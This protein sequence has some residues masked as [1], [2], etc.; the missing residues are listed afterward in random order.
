MQST[1]FYQQLDCEYFLSRSHYWGYGD[2]LPVVRQSPSSASHA[3]DQ[4]RFYARASLLA[5]GEAALMSI[6][7]LL[8]IFLPRNYDLNCAICD[9]APSALLSRTQPSIVVRGYAFGSQGAPLPLQPQSFQS[10]R[11]SPSFRLR[12]F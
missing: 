5:V 9:P 12:L 8:F 7:I 6:R 2:F 11:G 4:E 10:N 3:R 1:N